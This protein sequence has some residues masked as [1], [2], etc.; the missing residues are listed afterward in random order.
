MK[1][2]SV[3]EIDLDALDGNLA[4]LRGLAGDA[5]RLCPILKADAYGLGIEVL[6]RRIA[7][8]L[9]PRRDLIA[10]F[11]PQQAVELAACRLPVPLLLL[12]PV[13]SI[14]ADDPLFRP[15]LDGRL[16]LTVHGVEQLDRLRR[17][18]AA[19]GGAAA[20]HLEVDVGLGRGGIDPALFEEALR[21]ARRPGL[22][23][24]GVM[25]HFSDAKS[26]PA[27]TATQWRLLETELERHRALLPADLVVHVSSTYALLRDRRY[28]RS[29]VRF[30]LA[31]AG[32]GGESLPEHELLS[33]AQRLRPILSWR[34]RL[35]HAK[36]IP[37]GR[38]VGYG[39][40]WRAARSS[41]VGLVPV[42]YADG[43][44]SRCVGEAPHRVVVVD[45]AG[46]ARGFAAPVVGAVNMDQISVDLTDLVGDRPPESLVG[47]PVELIAADPRSPVHLPEV[48]RRAGM[49]PHEVI[50]RL[51]PRIPRVHLLRRGPILAKSLPPLAIE[52]LPAACEVGS[53]TW[54]ATRSP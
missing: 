45:P 38:A 6:A 53:A 29:M 27:L 19:E 28:H 16:H 3:I 49:I 12:M 40:T 14:E 33:A 8:R 23:L 34:S 5:C 44:P 17:T 2:T 25:A 24:A 13:E 22:R 11:S 32:L 20:V 41:V 1:V 30:G 9:D 48:A 46:P 39:S 51:H 26:D 42:G 18:A 21:G 54:A 36:R 31:W 35:V 7:R 15:V 50:C 4:A 37:A 43:Y 47:L 10:V 52:T